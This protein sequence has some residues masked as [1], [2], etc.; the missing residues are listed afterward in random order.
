MHD[1]VGHNVRGAQL[2]GPPNFS[3]IAPMIVF[4]HFKVGDFI[5]GSLIF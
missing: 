5:S 2:F 3:S 1:S 4:R